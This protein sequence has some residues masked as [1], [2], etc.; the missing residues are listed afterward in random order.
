MPRL[1]LTVI[2]DNV[3]LDLTNNLANININA[4]DNSQ[5]VTLYIDK[6]T[7]VKVNDNSAAAKDLISKDEGN[8][9]KQGGDGL[10]AVDDDTTDYLAH[11]ILA[12][13]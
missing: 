12:K 2:D 13:G 10:L 6:I 1:E 11:Y 5:F 8:L 7:G 9:I 4:S 3:E